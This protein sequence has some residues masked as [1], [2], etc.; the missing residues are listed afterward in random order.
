MIFFFK[1]PIFF[2]RGSKISHTF[3][4]TDGMSALCISKKHV[5]KQYL[6]KVNTFLGPGKKF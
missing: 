1:E 3:Q 2:E 5:F 4:S 6:T